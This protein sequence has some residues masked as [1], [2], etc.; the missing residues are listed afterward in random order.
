[1]VARKLTINF[2]EIFSRAHGNIE[3]QNKV[4]ESFIIIH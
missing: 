2:E 1:M 3:E 4:L